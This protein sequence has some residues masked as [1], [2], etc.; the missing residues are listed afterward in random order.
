MDFLDQSRT[1]QEKLDKAVAKAILG[2]TMM[3]W[4]RYAEAAADEV[5]TGTGWEYLMRTAMGR[6]PRA[7][8]VS[9]DPRKK[10]VDE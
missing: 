5:V 2:R 7:V 10:D 6:E 1:M 3:Q 9:F 8:L 4:D